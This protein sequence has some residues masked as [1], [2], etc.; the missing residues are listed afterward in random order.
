L[1]ANFFTKYSTAGKLG[2]AGL[3]T[4]S[5]H[6]LTSVQGGR[7]TMETSDAIGTSLTLELPLWNPAEDACPPVLTLPEATA[8]A[9]EAVIPTEFGTQ[10]V[11]IVDDD[12]FN[13]MVLLAQMPAPLE[14]ESAVN[15]R[16]AL[17][18]VMCRPYGLII[19]DID[20]PIMGGMEALQRIRAFQEKAGQTPSCIVAYSAN[21]SQ[22]N[23]AAYLAHGFDKC[24]RKPGSQKE[25][26]ALLC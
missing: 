9:S 7:L 25:V 22:Q 11:L 24:L 4:Y 21:D 13:R 18:A 26:L 10:R 2:G 5:S 8:G 20:M 12:E 1:R 6:L 15:G 14:V 16:A 23:H 19:M 17:E 3:G